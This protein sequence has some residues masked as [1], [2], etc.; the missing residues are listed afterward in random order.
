M[1]NEP[2]YELIRVHSDNTITPLT[3]SKNY[4]QLEVSRAVMM[5]SAPDGVIYQIREVQKVTNQW[6]VVNNE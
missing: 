6:R 5:K 3:Q 1:S 4:G 2:I